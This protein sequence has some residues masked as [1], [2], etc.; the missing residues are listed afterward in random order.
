MILVQRRS[1]I[2]DQIIQACKSARLPV[3]GSDRLKIGA[4]LAVRDLLAL[5]SFLTLPED[6][7]SLASA[8]RSPLFGWS[9]RVAFSSKPSRSRLEFSQ[10]YTIKMSS[11]PNAP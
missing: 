6:D 1:A 4:E 2:F 3:A 8:L 9:D 5:L 7:L 10:I 11:P